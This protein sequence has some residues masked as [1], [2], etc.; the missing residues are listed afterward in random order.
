[1]PISAGSRNWRHK[2]SEMNRRTHAL[3]ANGAAFIGSLGQRPTVHGPKSLIAE[4]AAHFRV[5]SRL[6]RFL[7]AVLEN[8]GVL[9]QADLNRSP[10]ARKRCARILSFLVCLL[11]V[12]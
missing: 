3:R 1:M 5:E 10:L 6:Q 2:D 9:P 7:G 12:G 4:S 11:L 8:P